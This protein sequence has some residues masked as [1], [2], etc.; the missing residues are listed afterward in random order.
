[1][2]QEYGQIKQFR[3][4]S[5]IV[6]VANI[7]MITNE[8]LENYNQGKLVKSTSDLRKKATALYSLKLVDTKIRYDLG[9]IWDTRNYFAHSILFDKKAVEKF[10]KQQVN[11][12]KNLSKVPPSVKIQTMI[13]NL[14]MCV[15]GF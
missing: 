9:I 8:L 1:M 6:L 10:F 12:L 13:K 2:W 3:R 5:V 7:E 15:N 4:P 14:A 11:S